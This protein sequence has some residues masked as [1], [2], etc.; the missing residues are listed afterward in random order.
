MII[1]RLRVEEGFFD[2]LDLEFSSGLNVLIGGRGVGKTSVIELLRF[3]L[4]VGSVSDSSKES[5]LHALSILQSSGRVIIELE[6]DGREVILSRSA[7]DPAPKTS[8]MHA[9]PI[10]FSQKEIETIG[11]NSRGKLELIDS[12]I[13]GISNKK[14]EIEKNHSEL[15]SLCVSL[16]ENKKENEETLV[17]NY[18]FSELYKKE[19]ELVRSQEGFQSK[20]EEIKIIQDNLNKVQE[21]INLEAVDE[22]NLM[23]VHKFFETRFKGLG[24]FTSN[25][26]DIP[27]KNP[28]ANSTIS[29]IK[30]AIESEDLVIREMMNRNELLMFR[31]QNTIDSLQSNRLVLE[32]T[33]RSLRN[34]VESYTQGAGNV[35]GELGRV[36]QEMATL[37]NLK[38]IRDEKLEK[39]RKIYDACQETMDRIARL[40]HEMFEERTAVSKSLNESLLPEIHTAVDRLA[41]QSEYTESLKQTLKGSGLKY[42]GIVELITSKVNPQ[43]LLYYVYTS[44][45]QDFSNVTGL[46]LDRATRILSFLYDTDLGPLLSTEIDDEIKFHLLDGQGYKAIGDLSIGQRCT[47]A[48]SAILENQS[49]VLVVDQPEDHLDNEFIANTLIK[50][51]SKRSHEAQTIVSSHNA[52]IPVL[53]NA[54]TVIN[55]DSDGRRGFVKHSGGIENTEIKR[56]IESIMEGGKSAFSQRAKFY[57]EA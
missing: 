57:M 49:R 48:L 22:Q 33:A 37:N 50:A 3:G 1:K 4:G 41:N 45:Y 56:V 14:N 5:K 55:L 42:N 24:D 21:K 26:P 36:R 52:N 2:H 12:F 46:P 43:H 47:V 34:Q 30:E 16:L 44:L 10:I 39:G 38:R 27:L 28:E 13:V 51:L 20:N 8:F 17:E 54:T 35:L 29:K 18:R 19:L 15:R 9:A 7:S 32:E 31:V 53:G 6:I 40:R 11:L 25:F 23:L